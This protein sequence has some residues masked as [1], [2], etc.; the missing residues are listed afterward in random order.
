MDFLAISGFDVKPGKSRDL[1]EWVRANSEALSA[2]APE[3]IDLVGIY[4]AMYSS[5]KL[6]G[7][8][9]IVWR[10]DS[11]GAMDRFAAAVPENPEL[12][13]LFEELDSFIDDR[14]GTGSSNELL[15]TVADTT[16]WGDIPDEG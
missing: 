1:Q 12:A 13:R 15:K 11:Y 14:L 2:N 8:Y 5:E 16:I 3:G 10:L 4:A 9:R 7:H 6:T